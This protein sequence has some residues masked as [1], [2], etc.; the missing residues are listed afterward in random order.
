[1]S[2]SFGETEHVTRLHKYT[3]LT[4]S[5]ACR[6]RVYIY[7]AEYRAV[8]SCEVTG[9]R[10]FT[11]FLKN[12]CPAAHNGGFMEEEGKGLNNFRFILVPRYTHSGNPRIIHTS[13]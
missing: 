11:L 1:M 5:P 12:T 13:L 9:T 6:R 7:I 3:V 2:L 8:V 10:L 4:Q